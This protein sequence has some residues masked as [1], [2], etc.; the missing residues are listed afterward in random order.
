I[1]TLHS[2][3]QRILSEHPVEAGLPPRVEVLDEVSSD[4]EF[5]R[6]WSDFQ[7]R[8][9]ADPALQ[10]TLL[11]FFGAGVRP[12]ALRALALAFD[13]NW[14][15]VDERVPRSVP[16][17]PPVRSLLATPLAAVDAVCAERTDCSRP[18]AEDG[19]RTRLDDI[20][21]HVLALRGTDDDLEL[22]DL[23]GEKPH[24]KPHS[25]AVGRTGSQRN[26]PDINGLRA[27]VAAAGDGLAGVRDRALAACA[28]R[29]GATI[30]GFTLAA[31]EERRAAGRLEFHDLLVLSRAL[32]R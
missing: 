10:R 4:V 20:A 27:R 18:S 3:A 2:F 19:L 5:D 22:L 8:L 13:Q 1:G 30:A 23:L 32:L 15:L 16:D 29:L 24:R 9:L 28:R 26:W 6:R 25:F 17:P 12:A 11:L 7:D 14:D 31:A 21:D